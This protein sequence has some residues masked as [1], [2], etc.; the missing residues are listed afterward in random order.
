MDEER[1]D[2]ENLKVYQKA[3]E[4]VDFAYRITKDFPKEEMFSLADQFKRASISI[5]LN[6]AE[7]S[8]GT[9][10]EFNRFLKIARRSVRECIAITEISCRQ[11]FIGDKAK[12]QSRSFC[13]E[14]SKMIHGLIKSLRG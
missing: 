9:K 11:K 8:G 1:F 5:C 7:G 12:Q 14:L 6:I 10:T 3:L 13:L 2:F 4:Y